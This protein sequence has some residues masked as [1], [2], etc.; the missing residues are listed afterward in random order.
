MSNPIKST[1]MKKVILFFACV[2]GLIANANADNYQPITRDQLPKKAQAF[3]TSY[4][5]E[6]KTSLVR[7]EIDV[8]EVSYDV[9][10]ADG[11]KVEFD[12]KGDWTDVDCG[13]NP[14]PVGIVPK[15][16]ENVIRTQYPEA[17]AIKIERD[18]N[19]YDV[20]LSNRIELTFNKKMQLVDI[21]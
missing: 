5:S 14:L 18:R 16:I 11:S 13:V 12:R 21:D 1:I 8:M 19:E 17:K 7:K 6:I 4:F 2:C 10:F 3:L 9:I 15:A 20:K